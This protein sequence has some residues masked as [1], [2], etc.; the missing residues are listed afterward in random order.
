M[1]AGKP[2]VLATRHFPPDVEARLSANHHSPFVRNPSWTAGQLINNGAETYLTLNLSQ[3]ITPQL[4]VR[5]GIEAAATA[6]D[7]VA[8][9]VSLAR[10][11]VDQRH[12]QCAEGQR[13][14]R[15]GPGEA[16]ALGVRADGKAGKV[17]DAEDGQSEGVAE[18]GRAHV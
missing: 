13:E 4:Q 3:Q 6:H 14:I 11:D 1:T 7:H 12:T 17:H 5:F 10:E 18:I 16:V 9:S 15:R 2:K 8:A